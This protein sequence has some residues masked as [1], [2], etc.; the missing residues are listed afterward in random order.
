RRRLS[1]RTQTVVPAKAG[2]HPSAGSKP[3]KWIPAFAGMTMGI[4]RSA[5][6]PDYRAEGESGLITHLVMGHFRKRTAARAAAM[7]AAIRSLMWG[8]KAK[9]IP[10]KPVPRKGGRRGGNAN[11]LAE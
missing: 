10:P 5:D 4:A 1:I 2:T 9:R 3:D 11:L 7:A 6:A 8:G